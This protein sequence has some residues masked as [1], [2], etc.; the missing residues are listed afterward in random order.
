LGDVQK[1]GGNIRR[2]TSKFFDGQEQPYGGL[3]RPRKVGGRTTHA[4]GDPSTEAGY[5]GREIFEY[6]AEYGQPRKISE[7]PGKAWRSLAAV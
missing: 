4:P 5:T 2:N 7:R 6:A 3:E 1:K